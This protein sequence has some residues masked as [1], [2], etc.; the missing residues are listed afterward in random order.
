M[1]S[2]E[3]EKTK[4]DVS[5]KL[6]DKFSS[7]GGFAS[8]LRKNKHKLPKTVVADAAIIEEAEH[9]LRHPK[10]RK[11]VDAQQ[12]SNAKRR[13]L[14]AADQVE[15][16]PNDYQGVMV[17]WVGLVLAKLMGAAALIFGGGYYLGLY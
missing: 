14:T 13:I 3:I 5:Q 1:D 9:N 4:S 11:R 12:V 8:Q 10:L 16:Q 7:K 15:V 2:S 6:A 17:G